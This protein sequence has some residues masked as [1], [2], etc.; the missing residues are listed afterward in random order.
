MISSTARDLPEHRDLVKEACLRQ[1]F[2][3]VMMEHLPASD[4]DAIAESMRMVDEAETYLGI[5]AFRYGYVPKGHDISIT[6]MEYNRAGER[7]IPRLMFLMHKDHPIRAEDVEIE[8]AEK[9]KAFKQRVQTEK[10]VRFFKSPADLRSE[11]I[12]TLSK[13]RERNP[14]PFHYV[15]DIPEPPEPYIAHPYTLLQTGRLIGRQ[16]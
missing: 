10:V 16:P 5:L 3:P 1:S 13:L 14:S 9:L 8:G 7:G 2:F 4:A 6:E 12:D 15:S 11:V